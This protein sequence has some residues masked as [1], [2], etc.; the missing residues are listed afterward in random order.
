MPT[1]NPE[2]LIALA[3][4]ASALA[5]AL[6]D[7]DDESGEEGDDEPLVRVDPDDDE[8]ASNNAVRPHIEPRVEGGGCWQMPDMR[9]T[10]VYPNRRA[11]HAELS[12]M[13]TIIHDAVT[14]L[15]GFDT[16]T[17]NRVTLPR[18]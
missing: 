12:I 16:V 9:T 18:K 7:A 10:V 13:L 2:E 8:P 14:N 11:A 3:Q 15:P 6:V 17:V 5:M 1:L 4:D